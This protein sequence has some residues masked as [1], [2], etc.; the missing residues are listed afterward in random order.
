MYI[1]NRFIYDNPVK[2]EKEAIRMVGQGRCPFCGSKIKYSERFDAK[3]C[4]FC[5][6][7]LEQACSDPT[8]E[9]CAY[10]PMRPQ[11]AIHR[12]EKKRL[13]RTYTK[14]EETII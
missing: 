7:W 3:Y 13:L 2:D 6:V 4:H 8:C 12:E 11:I 14:K 9:Y 1:D 10:R 5:D